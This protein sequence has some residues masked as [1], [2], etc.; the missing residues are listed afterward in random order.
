MLQSH[1]HSWESHVQSKALWIPWVDPLHGYTRG[2]PW[3][4]RGIDGYTLG[5]FRHAHEIHGYTHGFPGHTCGILGYTDMENTAQ[6]L[7]QR[8]R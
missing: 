3:F 5:I 2:I 1:V 4:P 8:R 6:Q 7:S